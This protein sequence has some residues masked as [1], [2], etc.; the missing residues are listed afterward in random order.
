VQ[1][2]PQAVADTLKGIRVLVVDND[3]PSQKL[4]KICLEKWG[5]AASAVETGVAAV[6]ALKSDC[7]DVC[8]MDILMPEMD[9]LTAIQLIR[10]EGNR[11][12]PIIVIT[13]FAT[14]DVIKQ[15][16]QVGADE[17]LTKPVNLTEL[18][19]K[20][21]QCYTSKQKRSNP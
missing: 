1:D 4:M 20:I 15:S 11:N 14:Q 13:A 19:R 7:Y 6:A 12:L 2:N 21:C 18:Q 9:G 3:P 5:C 10:A 8:L 17:V 16:F